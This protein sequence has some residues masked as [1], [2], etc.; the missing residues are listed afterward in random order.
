MT[1]PNNAELAASCTRYRSRESLILWMH[2][3][4]KVNI[5]DASKTLETVKDRNFVVWIENAGLKIFKGK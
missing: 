2:H 4:P 3:L 5:Y 1:K